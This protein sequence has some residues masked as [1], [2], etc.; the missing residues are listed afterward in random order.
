[1]RKLVNPNKKLRG[2]P[3]RLRSL[4]IWS[5]SFANNYPTD[6]QLDPVDAYWNYKIPVDLNLVEGQHSTPEV[7]RACAQE[8]INACYRLM[9][10]K[11]KTSGYSRVTCVVCLPNLFTSELCIYRELEYF[12]SHTIGHKN[13]YGESKVIVGRSLANEWSLVLPN[14]VQERGV[15]HN[16]HSPEDDWQDTGECWYFGE[17]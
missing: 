14:G 9:S 5:E 4:K 15:S 12:E 10:A 11:P 13:E 8:L 17:L 3:R 16:F 2:I 1:M 6:N 7:K